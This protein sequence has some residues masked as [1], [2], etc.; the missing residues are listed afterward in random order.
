MTGAAVAPERLPEGNKYTRRSA[1]EHAGGAGACARAESEHHAEGG[2]NTDKRVGNIQ[3][4]GWEICRQEGG[5]YTDR[6]REKERQD[7]T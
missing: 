7:W 1:W 2:K 6:G 4:G 5:K 3:T